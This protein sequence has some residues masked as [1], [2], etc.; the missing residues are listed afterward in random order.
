VRGL[1]TSRYVSSLSNVRYISAQQIIASSIGINNGNPVRTLDI[2]DTL[3][4][5]NPQAETTVRYVALITKND[6][7]DP[8]F[9]NIIYTKNGSNWL[10][11]TT[12]G[13]TAAAGNKVVWGGDKWVACGPNQ[14]PN[15][16]SIIYSFDGISWNNCTNTFSIKANSCAY[17]EDGS[18]N[19][20]WVAVGQDT[21]VLYNIKHSSDGINWVDGW[22][23]GSQYYSVR[24]NDVVWNGRIW[25][26]VGLYTP[27]T[28]N[29]QLYS[30]NGT[31]WYLTG[32]SYFDANANYGGLCVA[33]SSNVG[34]LIVAGGFSVTQGKSLQYTTDPASGWNPAISG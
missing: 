31:Y 15:V 21:N 17:G 19:P 1:G 23:P 24:A 5:I 29:Y 18:G 8:N 14:L 2:G 20:R 6:A 11:N 10:S 7:T 3:E 33:A 13:W 28:L 25:I 26:A 27:P 9:K 16:A 12:G 4:T 30:S 22:T 32:N 34:G